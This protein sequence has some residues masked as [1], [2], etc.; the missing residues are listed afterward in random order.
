MVV[1]LALL[2]AGW[3][4]GLAQGRRPKANKE[5]M[6]EKL[7]LSQKV[8]EALALENYAAISAKSK[9]LSAMS[10]AVEWQVLDNPD[11]VQQSAAFRRQVDAMARAADQKNL[12]AA[13]LAYVR[14][15]RSCVDCHK[16]VRGKTVASIETKP[17]VPTKPIL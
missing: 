10:Q 16:F 17:S 6:R 1:A 4:A 11:Y 5:F 3:T 15:T 8:L 13:T 9:R 7:E 12:D 14:M 2:L